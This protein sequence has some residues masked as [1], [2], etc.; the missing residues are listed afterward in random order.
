MI[1][2][3]DYDPAWVGRFEAL[4]K[5]YDGGRARLDRRPPGVPGGLE[6]GIRVLGYSVLS[7]SHPW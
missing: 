3:C 6:V 4:R 7:A 5:E 1:T 2:V